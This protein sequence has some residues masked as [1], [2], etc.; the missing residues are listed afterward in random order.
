MY[1]TS[2]LIEE[3]EHSQSVRVVFGV[4]KAR[5]WTV[6]CN[7]MEL[8]KEEQKCTNKTMCV[9]INRNKTF[10]KIWYQYLSFIRLLKLTKYMSMDQD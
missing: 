6:V 9:M 8:K 2:Y 1:V 10:E 7:D 4:V 3:S 5:V